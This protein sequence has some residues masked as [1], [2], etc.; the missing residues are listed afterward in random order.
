MFEQ[1]GRN[2]AIRRLRREL[3]ESIRSFPQGAHLI[4]YMPWQGEVAIVRVLHGSMDVE[5]LFGT[6]DPLRGIEDSKG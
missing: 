5:G 6:Y 3:G 4:V 1:I 2:P